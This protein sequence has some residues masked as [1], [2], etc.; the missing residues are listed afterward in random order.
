MATGE[1][2]VRWA[3]WMGG[4]TSG[5]TGD[6]VGGDK[7][8]T[9][10]RGVDVKSIPADRV[11]PDTAAEASSCSGSVAAWIGE[12][13]ATVC[14]A[15]VR[16]TFRERWWESPCLFSKNLPNSGSNSWKRSTVCF[17]P[18][19]SRQ[20]IIPFQLQADFT[21]SCLAT[22]LSNCWFSLVKS[23]FMVVPLFFRFSRTYIICIFVVSLRNLTIM[24]GGE[25]SVFNRFLGRG[26]TATISC[27]W[28]TV[29]SQSSHH[30][31]EVLLAQFSLYVHKGGLKPDS[32]HLYSH[33]IG[34]WYS[35]A[36]C[37]NQIDDSWLIIVVGSLQ[38]I[39]PHWWFSRILFE[40]VDSD[41]RFP[42][43]FFKHVSIFVCMAVKIYSLSQVILCLGHIK[44]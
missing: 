44:A 15:T 27:V 4:A 21:R 5:L 43:I 14:W 2:S 18:S 26:C 17:F 11:W 16:F 13:C 20:L 7:G 31:Q 24:G 12:S 22:R 40:S 9:S 6:A 23:S 41:F 3:F 33:N 38:P 39:N 29:S 42:S 37:P 32:F 25:V 36:Q 19:F 1:D 30:P 28:R 8:C 34:R 10:G 35:Y